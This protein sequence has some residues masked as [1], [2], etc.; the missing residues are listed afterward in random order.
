[1]DE[2]WAQLFDEVYGQFIVPNEIAAQRY[3]LKQRAFEAHPILIELAKDGDPGDEEE[4]T[5]RR[6]TTEYGILATQIGSNSS[7]IWKILVTIDQIGARHGDPPV[8]PLVE[9]ASTA[10]PG[11]GYFKWDHL[12]ECDIEMRDEEKPGLTEE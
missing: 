4:I 12:V 8:S 5:R 6:S 9:S 1:M 11:H 7:Y 10:G 2:Q 3:T